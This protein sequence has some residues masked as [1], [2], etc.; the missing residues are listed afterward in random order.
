MKDI[1]IIRSDGRSMLL[2]GSECIEVS[3]YNVRSSAN[4]VAELCI[5]IKGVST[6]FELST[7]LVELT[8]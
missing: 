8:Q 6:E 1:K 7:N 5:T 2:I 3:D 4:G